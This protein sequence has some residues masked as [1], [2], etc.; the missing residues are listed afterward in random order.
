MTAG[1]GKG[2]WISYG[3]HASGKKGVFEKDN[4]KAIDGFRSLINS[5]TT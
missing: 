4:Q 5:L 1:T 2:P 3:E